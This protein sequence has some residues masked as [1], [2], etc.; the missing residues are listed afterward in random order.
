LSGVAAGIGVEGGGANG[1]TGAGTGIGGMAW[2]IGVG[3]GAPVS[4]AP[5]PS[6]VPGGGGG[7]GRGAVGPPSGEVWP[8]VEAGAG[9]VGTFRVGK[10]MAINW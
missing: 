5:V 4:G 1:V 9:H 3:S 7:G 10:F 6:S 8:A 2:G